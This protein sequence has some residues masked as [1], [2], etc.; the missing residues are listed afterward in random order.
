MT[1]GIQYTQTIKTKKI[2]PMEAINYLTPGTFTSGKKNLVSSFGSMLS[3]LS[4][5]SVPS[6]VVQLEEKNN[7]DEIDLLSQ[8]GILSGT[9]LICISD[10]DDKILYVN[11]KFC[12][13]S[14]YEQEEL[15][16]R[17]NNLFIRREMTF[18][19]RK[20]LQT[21]IEDGR[22]WQSEIKNRK[23]DG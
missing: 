23:K 9:T 19:D 14:G 18:E 4:G 13:V 3:F 8:M 10:L 15:I 6:T 16:G 2:K 21:T 7:E 1:P 20:E 22:V 11:D 17:Q 12:E 5:Q